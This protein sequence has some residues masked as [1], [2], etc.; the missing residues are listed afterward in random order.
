MGAADDRIPPMRGAASGA[1]RAGQNRGAARIGDLVSIASPAAALRVA[2]GA[3]FSMRASVVPDRAR[4]DVAGKR[5]A[6]AER[7]RYR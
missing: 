5:G 2:R 1:A 3:P 7:T 4:P 6:R